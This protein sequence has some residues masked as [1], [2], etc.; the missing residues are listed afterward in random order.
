MHV[1]VCVHVY[2]CTHTAAIPPRAPVSQEDDACMHVICVCV[3][4]TLTIARHIP[5]GTVII[6][7]KTTVMPPTPALSPPHVKA[8]PNCR[9]KS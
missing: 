7:F 8:H 2:T 6:D 3:Y 4:T 1:C 5:H 9:L